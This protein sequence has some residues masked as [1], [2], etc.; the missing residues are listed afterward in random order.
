MKKNV[1]LNTWKAITSRIHKG[2]EGLYNK[3]NTEVLG[4]ELILELVLPGLDKKDVQID[5]EDGFLTITA[6]H[7]N[8]EEERGDG[9]WK[10]VSSS[11]I[12]KRHVKVPKDL[13]GEDLSAQMKNGVLKVYMNR[14]L[15]KKKSV[16][17]I[18]IA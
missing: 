3:A 14:R 4:K 8:Q 6:K 17:Q 11:R 10:T 12:L 18:N 16:K 7:Q 1:I 5:L 15:H 2:W 9:Y 13:T